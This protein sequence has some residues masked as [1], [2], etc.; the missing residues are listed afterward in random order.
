MFGVASDIKE[1][2]FK[3]HKPI[4]QNLDDS[5]CIT[6]C[7]YFNVDGNNFHTLRTK[8]VQVM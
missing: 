2:D 3:A 4:Y 1:G 7:P 5:Q 8:D 6:N